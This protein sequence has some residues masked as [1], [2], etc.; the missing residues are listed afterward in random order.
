MAWGRV[1][2]WIPLLFLGG[3]QSGQVHFGQTREAGGLPGLLFPSGSDYLVAHM[4]DS[5]AQRQNRDMR[6]WCPPCFTGPQ[7]LD[8]RLVSCSPASKLPPLGRPQ[9]EQ[10]RSGSFTCPLKSL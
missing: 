8:C 9:S 6:P 10:Q 1:L 5:L 3:M 4:P 7:F 2:V